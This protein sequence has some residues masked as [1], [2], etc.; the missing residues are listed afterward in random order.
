MLALS[1]PLVECRTIGCLQPPGGG[2]ERSR[3]KLSELCGFALKDTKSF[4]VT[5]AVGARWQGIGG[6]H[7]KTYITCN[8][9]LWMWMSWMNFQ[10]FHSNCWKPC[11]FFG[12]QKN[13]LQPRLSATSEAGIPNCGQLEVVPR[14]SAC[15]ALETLS[16]FQEVLASSKEIQK[17]FSEAMF[18]PIWGF[19]VFQVVPGS[20]VAAL[21]DGIQ[22]ALRGHPS[23][24]FKWFSLIHGILP[25][26]FPA[27]S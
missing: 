11:C 3:K 8:S 6:N 14:G 16:G 17:S 22:S 7:I 24:T 21:E 19:Q 9:L 12:R 27:F 25:I 18:V 20:M 26:G 10:N 15:V 23:R 1:A 13:A 4:P 2:A 5:A